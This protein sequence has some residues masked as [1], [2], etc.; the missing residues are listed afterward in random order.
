MPRYSVIQ[1]FQSDAKI[2]LVFTESAFPYVLEH[3]AF[4]RRY[5]LRTRRNNVQTGGRTYTQ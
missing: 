4:V 3:L 5:T 1:N 2:S